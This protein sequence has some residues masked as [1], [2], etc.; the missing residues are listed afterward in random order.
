[1]IWVMSLPENIFLMSVNLIRGIHFIYIFFNSSIRLSCVFSSEWYPLKAKRNC[2]SVLTISIEF[3]RTFCIKEVKPWKRKEQLWQRQATHSRIPQWEGLGGGEQ[4][5]HILY[6][7]QCSYIWES[8][9]THM[10]AIECDRSWALSN[11]DLLHWA[12]GNMREPI[13][14]RWELLAN[15]TARE[16]PEWRTAEQSIP[17]SPATG[18]RA[19]LM[20]VSMWP[21]RA[22]S[23]EQGWGKQGECDD[24][25]ILPFPTSTR[26]SCW[27]PGQTSG[28]KCNWEESAKAIPIWAVWCS[29]DSSWNPTKDGTVSGRATDR[30]LSTECAQL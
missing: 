8:K 18:T 16:G 5:G 28:S 22:L 4:S 30:V 2:V 1:M 20:V 29:E 27:W 15:C 26:N 25:P 21:S 23:V 7:W 6:F 9:D 11:T 14:C 17:S 24:W 19:Q 12:V 13:V 10:W 3:L